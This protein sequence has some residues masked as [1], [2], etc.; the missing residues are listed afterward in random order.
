MSEVEFQAGPPDSP[1]ASPTSE[2]TA[3]L[4][5]KPPS[6]RRRPSMFINLLFGF[7]YAIALPLL[8]MP[9][10]GILVI[11]VIFIFHKAYINSFTNKTP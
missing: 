6:R 3:A 2:P 11:V 8:M 7:G 1:D 9:P 4:K 10:V 5:E